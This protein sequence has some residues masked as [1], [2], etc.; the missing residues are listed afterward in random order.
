MDIALHSIFILGMLIFCMLFK[1][2]EVAISTASE[3]GISMLDVD[4]NKQAKRVLKLISGT[5]RSTSVRQW[6]E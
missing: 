2:S 4:E 1:I 5:A 3:L 6:R